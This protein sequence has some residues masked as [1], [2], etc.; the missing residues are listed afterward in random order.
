[1]EL[2]CV[3][4]NVN[5]FVYIVCDAKASILRK[6]KK[7]PTIILKFVHIVIFF[8]ELDKESRSQKSKSHGRS[9]K[10]PCGIQTVM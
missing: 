5:I 3:T 4:E 9:L 2:K 1:M 8:N 10:I 7:N 6:R